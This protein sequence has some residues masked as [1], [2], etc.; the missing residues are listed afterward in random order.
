MLGESILDPKLIAMFLDC[1]LSKPVKL[2]NGGGVY[3]G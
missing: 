3:E 1:E 2:V